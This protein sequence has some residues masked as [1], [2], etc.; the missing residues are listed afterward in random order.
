M[1]SPP[2]RVP[3]FCN[4]FSAGALFCLFLLPPPHPDQSY[5]TITTLS[6]PTNVT[7]SAPRPPAACRRPRFLLY[8]EPFVVET[9]FFSSVSHTRIRSSRLLLPPPLVDPGRRPRNNGKPPLPK[10]TTHASPLSTTTQ[11]AQDKPI[12]PRSQ[13]HPRP[14]SLWPRPE[15]WLAQCPPLRSLP[16]RPCSKCPARRPCTFAATQRLFFV[17]FFFFG[18]V[19]SFCV[20]VIGD[21]T[22]QSFLRQ[23]THREKANNSHVPFGR[24]MIAVHPHRR[25]SQ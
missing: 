14:S 25:P 19:C 9:P 12:H 10:S 21:F 23:I 5:H 16:S 3:L 13:L 20:T 22:F 11:H 1:A 17:G 4:C 15:S 6:K 18:C 24:A 2:S 8:C 7:T